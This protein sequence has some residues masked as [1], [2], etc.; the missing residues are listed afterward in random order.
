VHVN[1]KSC[2]R[3]AWG[4]TVQREKMTDASSF[5]SL[6]GRDHQGATK[7]GKGSAQGRHKADVRRETSAGTP[8]L[9]HGN[10][11]GGPDGIKKWEKKEKKRI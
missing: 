6:R 5:K 9:N 3:G 4:M 10:N 11:W 1:L 7:D 2:A 8:K